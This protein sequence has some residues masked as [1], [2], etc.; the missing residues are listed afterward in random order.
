MENWFNWFYWFSQLYWLIHMVFK[1][2]RMNILLFHFLKLR[3]NWRTVHKTEPHVYISRTPDSLK[4]WQE[5]AKVKSLC[6]TFQRVKGQ[7]IIY[8]TL[9]REY[10]QYTYRYPRSNM[11]Y[12]TKF[13]KL[14]FFEKWINN[15]VLQLVLKSCESNC[16]FN[17]FK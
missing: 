9:N 2:L 8:A 16:L 12:P 13:E 6:I 10:R 17:I 1:Q 3:K 4:F 15:N 11:S 7:G 5:Q 14:T